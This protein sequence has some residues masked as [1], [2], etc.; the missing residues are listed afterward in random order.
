ML[1]CIVV[2]HVKLR[3]P[4]KAKSPI[5]GKVTREVLLILQIG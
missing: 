4:K 2:P 5:L 1:Y 3:E